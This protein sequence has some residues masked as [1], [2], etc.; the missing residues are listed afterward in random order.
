MAKP[1]NDELRDQIVTQAT[2]MFLQNGYD[3]VK[4]KDIAQRC[5]ITASLLQYYFPKRSDMV[6]Q[7]FFDV[8]ERV[9]VF[10]FDQCGPRMKDELGDDAELAAIAIFYK[11][12]Y[13]ILQ[14]NND[15]LLRLYTVIL[16]DVPVLK[17]GTDILW[18][19]MGTIIWPGKTYRSKA[20]GY[21]IN[22]MLASFVRIHFDDPM[23][24]S[25]DWFIDFALEGY[26][27]MVHVPA[28][29]LERIT[30]LTEAVLAQQQTHAFIDEVLSGV[31]DL[32]A[33]GSGL[34]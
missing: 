1:R 3:N 23:G 7:Y 26:Y 8:I 15:R 33:G 28:D 21:A 12:F 30:A 14:A 18:S 24:N 2:A 19:R 11:I 22:G 9:N 17:A 16:Y 32:C 31:D 4:L 5:D 29:L 13:N 20:A 6:V 27:S 25:L 10:I 34:K